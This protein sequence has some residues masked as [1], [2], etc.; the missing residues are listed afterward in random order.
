MEKTMCLPALDGTPLAADLHLPPDGRTPHAAVLLA[1]AMGVPRRFYRPLA[2]YFAEGG[3]AVLVPDYRGIAG[4]APPVLRGFEASL[5]DWADLDLRGALAFLQR[6]LPGV[7]LT[8]F[9]HSVG[10]Q[11]LGLIPDP[12]IARAL[13]VGSQHGHWRNWHTPRARLAMAALWWVAI[14][15]LTTILGK[16]PMKRIGGGEDLP[17]GVAQEW[18]RWGRARDYL[19]G[20]ALRRG[21]S[22]FASFTGELL[23]YAITDD[24]YAPPCS[25]APLVDAFTQARTELVHVAPE[26]VGLARLGHFGAFRAEARALWGEWRDWLLEATMM[27]AELPATEESA[28]AA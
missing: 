26:R 16:L 7:P 12:P 17:K 2:T 6:R 21:P 27:T 25:V 13:M 19:V 3:L 28:H 5:H 9:G 24:P 15:T 1:P 8:W 4:S 11:L 18:A 22:G 23:A 20:Y 14:P 10:G